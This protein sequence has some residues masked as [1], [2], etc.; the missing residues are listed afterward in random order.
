MPDRV[1]LLAA[2]IA[3]VLVAVN[4]LC[5]VGFVLWVTGG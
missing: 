2:A 1:G 4:V 5:L 3:A